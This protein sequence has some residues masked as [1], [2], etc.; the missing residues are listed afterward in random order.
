MNEAEQDAGLPQTPGYRYAELLGDELFLAGQVPQDRS[1]AIVSAGDPAGQA[2]VCLDNMA[3]V[4]DVNDFTIG[5]VRRLVIYVVGGQENLTAA[6]AGVV[7]WFDDSV[8]PATLLGVNRLGYPEQIVE[9]D[10]T[11]VRTPRP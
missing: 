7:D 3:T 4:V 2:A 9:I 10:A 1:G 8:P 6:W 5:D 11:V